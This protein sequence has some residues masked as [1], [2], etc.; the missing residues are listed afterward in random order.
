[1]ERHT[2][3]HLVPHQR[4]Q[5]GLAGLLVFNGLDPLILVL[6]PQVAAGAIVARVRRAGARWWVYL[7]PLA[8]ILAVSLVVW[9]GWPG[10]LL[11]YRELLI[12]G[13]WNSAVWPFG[14]P[15]GLGLLWWAWR[16]G[17]ERFG[18]VATPLLFPYVNMPSYLGLLAVLAIRWPR[19]ALLAW[20]VMAALVGWLIVSL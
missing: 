11:S 12:S 17:D 19:W 8:V 7:A 5:H 6:K 16:T 13:D 3:L 10:G 18:I 2:D 4:V 9:R 20:L 15:F 1:V 14:L